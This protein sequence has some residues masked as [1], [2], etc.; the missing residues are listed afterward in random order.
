MGERLGVAVAFVVG[1]GEVVAGGDGV[2]VGDM[3]SGEEVGRVVA[4]GG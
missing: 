1:I 4:T 2:L 3:A